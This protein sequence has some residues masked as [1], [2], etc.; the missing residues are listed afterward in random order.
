MRPSSILRF[1]LSLVASLVLLSGLVTTAI[2]LARPEAAVVTDELDKPVMATQ[3]EFLATAMQR[4][5]ARIATHPQTLECFATAS[6]AVCQAQ[7][8]SLHA[9]N[10]DATVLFVTAGQNSC[11]PAFCPATRGS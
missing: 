1:G 11:Y 2:Y 4:T 6:P 8:A 3:I 7:V 10:Q 9:L 5:A